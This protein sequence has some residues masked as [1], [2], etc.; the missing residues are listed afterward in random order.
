[1]GC[2]KHN[3]IVLKISPQTLKIYEKWWDIVI[4]NYNFIQKLY[5]ISHHLNM[6][7]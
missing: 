7:N 3:L 5:K 4:K 6:C 1:M 2:E